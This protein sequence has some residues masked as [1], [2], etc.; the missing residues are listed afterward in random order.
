MVWVPG[1]IFELGKELN[2]DIDGDYTPVSVVTLTGF[3]LSKYPVTQAQYEAVM[4]T[5]PSHFT[6]TND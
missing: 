1:G 3:Y 5:N 2:P 6:G 4:G